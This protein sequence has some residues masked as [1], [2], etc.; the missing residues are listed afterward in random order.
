MNKKQRRNLIIAAIFVLVIFMFFRKRSGYEMPKFAGMSKDDAGKLY[1]TTLSLINQ[2]S[3]S[4]SEIAIANG[5][6][7]VARNLGL[8]AQKAQ[9]DLSFEYNK[10][11]ASITPV[12]KTNT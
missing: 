2:D 6:P 1:E 11:V 8:D 10:Y 4:K 7:E 9:N 5:Q 12:T 3:E